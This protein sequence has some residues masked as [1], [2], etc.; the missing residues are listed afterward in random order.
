V[1]FDPN[2][3]LDAED[4][5]V[6]AALRTMYVSADP[7]PDLVD[8][9]LFAI[10][11]DNIDIELAAI[12]AEYTGATGARSTENTRTVT[13]ESSSLRITVSV[14]EDD[15]RYLDGWIEPAGELEIELITPTARFGTRSDEG[16]RFAFASVPAG[17]IHLEVLPTAGSTVR[18]TRRVVTQRLVL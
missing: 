11:L 3:P 8:R 18:L 7:A 16:G 5:A 10:D 1:N 15:S 17:Q 6:L 2:D 12:T 4:V 13:F 14:P 9:V